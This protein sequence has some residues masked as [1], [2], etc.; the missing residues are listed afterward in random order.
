MPPPLSNSVTPS[1]IRLFT[2]LLGGGLE[3]AEL[4]LEVA[5]GGVGER[6]GRE[7]EGSGPGWQGRFKRREG[8]AVEGSDVLINHVSC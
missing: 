8:I 5:Q 6:E 7:H 2:F 3:A 1:Q 4:T